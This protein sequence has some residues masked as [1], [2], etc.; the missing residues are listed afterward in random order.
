MIES[1]EYDDGYLYVMHFGTPQK[2]VVTNPNKEPSRTG[3]IIPYHD[4][5]NNEDITVYENEI[6]VKES[7]DANTYGMTVDDWE[8]YEEYLNK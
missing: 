4:W 3:K 5:C 7:S 2:N 8:C 1:D 6:I